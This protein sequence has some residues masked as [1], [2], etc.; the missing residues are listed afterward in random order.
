MIMTYTLTASATASRASFSASM[1]LDII[2]LL[3]NI[4]ESLSLSSILRK[5]VKYNDDEESQTLES[6]RRH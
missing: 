5:C 3:R 2:G 4:G 6:H 1:K